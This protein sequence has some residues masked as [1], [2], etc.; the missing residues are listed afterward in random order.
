M[1]KENK[2]KHLFLSHHT[3]FISL[4]L[5]VLLLVVHPFEMEKYKVQPIEKNQAGKHAYEVFSDLDSDGISEKIRFSN[6][7]NTKFSSVLV[8]KK[9]KVL[10]QWNFEGQVDRRSFTYCTGD[11]DKNGYKEIYLFT[12]NNDS[13]FLHITEPFPDKKIL[14][15]K[16]FIHT[17]RKTKTSYPDI[18]IH[19]GGFA[20]FDMHPP[21]EF[22]F[23]IMAGY[24]KEPRKVCIY[25][26]QD[27]SLTLSPL[28]GAFLAHPEHF[29]FDN[30]QI[31]EITADAAAQGNYPEDFPYTD[32]KG[33]LMVFDHKLDFYFDPL[34]FRKYPMRLKVE[35]FSYEGKETCLWVFRNY[36]GTRDIASGLY[37]IDKQGDVKHQ[38]VLEQIPVYRKSS[39]LNINNKLYL[40]S[41]QGPVYAFNHQL[42]KIDRFHLPGIKV[43]TPV[44][45]G[46]IGGSENDEFLFKGKNPNELIITQHN[47]KHPVHLELPNHK[48]R[49]FSI[50]KKENEKYLHIQTDQTGTLYRYAVNP[51]YV[52]RYPLYVALFAAVWAFVWGISHIQSLFI[53][54]KYETHRKINELQLK[55]V[56]NHIEPHFTF[57]LL[58]SISALLYEK[59]TE[60]ANKLTVQYA[61]LL[62]HAVVHSDQ[63]IIPLSDELDYVKRYLEIEKYRCDNH[64]DYHIEVA[65][66]VEK[67]LD[68]PKMLLFTFVENAVKHGIRHLE[69]EGY[70]QLLAYKSNGIYQVEI[71]DNGVGMKKAA[72]LD[73]SSTGT[74][75]QTVDKILT[76][77]Q[78]ITKK[79]IRYQII[80]L[81]GED[82]SSTGTKVRLKIPGQ[83]SSGVKKVIPFTKTRINGTTQNF[84]QT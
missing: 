41:T 69:S 61:K 79:K 5:F 8:F 39:I 28:S 37:V 81:N 4:I 2:L 24:N 23:S 16:R 59:E 75:L 47:L 63:M 76:Y 9:G 29:D 31:P 12:Y 17:Y 10:D 30:D 45:T 43:G 67:D 51:W 20:D 22:Y 11:Y 66:E 14:V 13:L 26:I 7:H 74:G 64:F 32:Q 42:E 77:Y 1:A 46:D 78:E 15:R 40:I 70:I 6:F 33:W 18:H 57:N 71:S 55:S 56:K 65:S 80:D 50:R 54:R 82:H 73:T 53:R 35:P 48:S 52:F 38:K 60:K 19:T 21:G 3:L 84:R 72:Q 27:D 58:N 49:L 62:R 68:I 44:Y 34:S 25:N 83:S 36:K